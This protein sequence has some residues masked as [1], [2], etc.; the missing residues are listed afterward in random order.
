MFIW[1]NQENYPRI[2]NKYS[3]STSS[4]TKS[5]GSK[6]LLWPRIRITETVPFAF[7]SFLWASNLLKFCVFS[8]TTS[9]NTSN[10]L[11]LYYLNRYEP[12][13]DKTYNK[14]YTT[15]KN[16]DQPRHPCSLIRVFADCM[17]FLQPL[18]YPKRD[19]REALPYWVDVQ[20]DLSLCWSNKSY[21]RFCHALAQMV[22]TEVTTLALQNPDMS[23]LCKQ[24]RS[25]S[26]GFWRSQLIWICTV[27]H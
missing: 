3:S 1:R 6:Y 22:I 19:T 4:P 26:V 2:I 18:P 23:C 21:W 12:V 13:H 9:W 24:C 7:S 15:S 5:D 10:K 16:S 11:K 8:V 17:C 25:R 20:A 14:T 27:C